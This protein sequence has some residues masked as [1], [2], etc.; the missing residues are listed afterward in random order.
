MAIIYRTFILYLVVVIA[1]RLMGKRQIGELQPFE[2]ATAIM[3]SE[4]AAIP[5]QDINESIINGIIP[6]AT[7]LAAQLLISFL[8][9]KSLTIRKLIC[10]KPRILVQNGR[11]VEKNLRK[12]MYTVNDLTEQLR[13]RGITNVGDVEFAVLETNGQLSV[14]NKSQKRPVTAEDIGVK[15]PYEGLSIDLI[16][17]GVISNENLK[18]A[19]LD[20]KWLIDELKLKGYYST[21]DIFYASLDTQGQI[22][23]QPREKK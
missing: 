1:M 10:G 19:G 5:A 4:L 21:N 9:I 8:S 3:I 14:I 20:K 7:L 13:M 18:M 6:I 15:T 2:L 22:F 12:E 23:V 11:L 16:I 17:D